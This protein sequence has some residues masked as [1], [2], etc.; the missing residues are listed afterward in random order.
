MASASGPCSARGRTR[1]LRLNSRTGKLLTWVLACASLTLAAGTRSYP[2]RRPGS[3]AASPHVQRTLDWLRDEGAPRRRVRVLFYGQSFSEQG[4]WQGVAQELRRR[5][6]HAELEIENRALGGFPA[7]LLVR[8]AE[9]DV[10]PYYPD[11][12]VFH[13]FGAHDR[14]EELIRNVRARTT[15]EILLQNDYVMRARDLSEETHPEHLQ[16]QAEHWDA[17]MNHRFLP[18]LARKYGTALCDHRA[19]FKAYLRAHGLAPEVMLLRDLHLNAFGE[20]LVLEAVKDCLQEQGPP[21]AGDEPP[22]AQS[23]IR[24]HRVGQAVQETE[25]RLR[26]LFRGNRVDAILGNGGTQSARVWIDGQA[27]STRRELYAF[28]RALPTPGGKWPAV[29]SISS[30]V[31]PEPEEWT[32]DVQ[33]DTRPGVFAFSLHGSRTGFDGTGTSDRR[34]VS[35]SR[36]VVL[37]A[38]DWN[39]EYALSLAALDSVPVRVRVTFGVRPMFVDRLAPCEHCNQASRE[40]AVTVVQGLDNGEHVIEIESGP[41]FPRVRELRVFTPP[42]G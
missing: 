11:L 40:E 39:L 25:G 36:R 2:E 29:L 9:T 5:Y 28:T 8:T 18:T 17:F 35:H 20:W 42:G 31:T 14:Y 23:W 6:P 7:Q 41:S 21:R 24:S 13:A 10:Y 4:W 38:A 34:F 3:L 32:L 1:P 33:R 15:A 30:E 37:E 12:L 26:L 27:P 22:P 19:D 16:P